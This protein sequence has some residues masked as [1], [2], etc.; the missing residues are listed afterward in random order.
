MGRDVPD[1][2]LSMDAVDLVRDRRPI[3]RGLAWT[4]R[5]GERWAVLGANGSGK[6]SLLQLASTYAMPSR[7]TVHVLGARVG[8]V[9][10]R[11][12][13]T[14]IGYSSAP[15]QR[16]LDPRLHVLAAV[17]AGKYA[18][19]T[20]WREVYDDGDCERA[21]EL[22]H[23]VGL[24]GLEER[25]VHTLS[26]GETQR[27]HLA[28]S[29]MNRPELLLLDEVAAGL[30]IGAR[31]QLVE[32]LGGLGTRDHV[33]AVVLVTH[34][35]EEIPPGFTHALLLR[36]GRIL[37]AGAIDDTLTSTTL[38]ECFGVP[39]VVTRQ[40]GRFSCRGG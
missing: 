2:A 17:A 22:L 26:E 5:G 14:R 11:E 6:T 29:L 40:D 21:V 35:I 9:D 34:H 4:V 37:A 15:L 18:M 7:G 27:L 12:L 31:E 33:R 3:L 13:R 19:L 39:L 32:L 10:V 1:V 8:R 30:D 25:R 28:R 20:R 36:G 23:E 38:S 16:A 24:S